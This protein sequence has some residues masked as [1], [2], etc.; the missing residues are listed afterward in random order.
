M[1]VGKMGTTSRPRPLM[2][3][4]KSVFPLYFVIFSCYA[5][6]RNH[7]Q[8]PLLTS[9]LGITVSFLKPIAKSKTFRDTND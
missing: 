2:L 5:K 9:W 3:S 1:P 7:R 8:Q 4:W 6:S